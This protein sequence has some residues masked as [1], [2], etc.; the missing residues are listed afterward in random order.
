M[1][2]DPSFD[3][4]GRKADRNGITPAQHGIRRMLASVGKG[5]GQRLDSLRAG[6][7]FKFAGRTWTYL[8]KNRGAGGLSNV[9]DAHG[10]RTM[11]PASTLVRIVEV[12]RAT[13][14]TKAKPSK[15]AAKK[16][17]ARR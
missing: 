5:F 10:A 17:T 14:S 9:T 12:K 4:R 8:G 1:S 3:K 6:T 7:A 2:F 16:T 15:P 13:K 11:L